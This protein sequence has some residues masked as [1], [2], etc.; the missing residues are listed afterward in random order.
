MSGQALRFW[1]DAK[2]IWFELFNLVLKIWSNLRVYSSKLQSTYHSYIRRRSRSYTYEST[3]RTSS[4]LFLHPSVIC[5]FQ[6]SY[7]AFMIQDGHV[8]AR[9][10]MNDWFAMEAGKWE[11]RTDIDVGALFVVKFAAWN[12]GDRSDALVLT[13]P[14]VLLAGRRGRSQTFQS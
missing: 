10:A 4:L 2:T 3:L 1:E 12:D 9:S 8:E 13:L 14:F 11:D 6:T 5:F 7:R